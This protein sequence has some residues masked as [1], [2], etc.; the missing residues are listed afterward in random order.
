VR[1]KVL[2]GAWVHAYRCVAEAWMLFCDFDG[3][4]GFGE[5]GACDHEFLDA[6]GEGAL[7]DGGEVGGVALGAVVE[8]AEDG[9]GEV[10]AD[11]GVV[12]IWCG[13]G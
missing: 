7:E 3:V 13:R 12:R 9:V 5:V 11:L 6:G 8:A 4:F 2:R 1:V 10:Y